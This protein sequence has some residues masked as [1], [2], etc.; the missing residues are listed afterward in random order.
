MLISCVF[1]FQN[2][3]I[4]YLILNVTFWHNIT[5][6]ATSHSG[7]VG[8]NLEDRGAGPSVW[9]DLGVT[10]LASLGG[11]HL[12]N[13]AR[14]SFQHHKAI[15]AQSG[16]LHGVGVGGPGIACLEVKVCICHHCWG[17]QVS[18]RPLD[19]SKNARRC[20]CYY[21]QLQRALFCV[22][23]CDNKL[24]KMFETIETAS[25]CKS[26]RTVIHYFQYDRT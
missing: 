22:R 6:I 10:V 14:T 17:S 13:L 7:E 3:L 9:T 2:R 23:N 25:R 4:V 16:A 11:G 15:L 8:V 12:H 21:S 18:T 26:H 5:D 19:T 1:I 24:M 20:S